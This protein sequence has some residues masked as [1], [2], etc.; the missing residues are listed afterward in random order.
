MC[1]L[2]PCLRWTEAVK[3]FERSQPGDASVMRRTFLSGSEDARSVVEEQRVPSTDVFVGDVVRLRAGDVCPADLVVTYTVAEAQASRRAIA[4]GACIRGLQWIRGRTLDPDPELASQYQQQEP[5][6]RFHP[7]ACRARGPGG[8]LDETES[9]GLLPLASDHVIPCG[10]VLERGTVEGVA[11]A[12]GEG[13]LWGRMI[14]AGEWPGSADLGESAAGGLE[15]GR[16]CAEAVVA[17]VRQGRGG[18]GVDRWERVLSGASAA[19]GGANDESVGRAGDTAVGSGG[20]GG[21]GGHTGQLMQ[22]KQ[23]S[24]EMGTLSHRRGGAGPGRGH[25]GEQ[26]EAGD[27]LGPSVDEAGDSN[28]S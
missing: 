14:L 27:A 6:S 3:R 18:D 22:M 13:T 28:G 10:A 24:G 4:S 19:S 16:E 21:R 25:G 15:R 5:P 7:I 9:G 17:L 12:T 1:C 23:L 11:V 2:L 8:P 26:G 20:A